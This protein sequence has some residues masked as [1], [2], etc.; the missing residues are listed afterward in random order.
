[1]IKFYFKVF[2]VNF[3][4]MVAFI[5]LFSLLRPE[6]APAAPTAVDIGFAF[7]LF[8]AMAA[9]ALH[10]LNILMVKRQA[11]KTALPDLYSTAQELELNVS[12]PYEKLFDLCRRYVTDKAAYTV[13]EEDQAKG[14]ISARTPWSW[15]GYG[16]TFSI[17]FSEI[18]DGSAKVRIS[19]KPRMPAVLLDYGENLGNVLRA[20]DYI[21]TNAH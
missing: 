19:S 1:M 20:R 12:M 3:I 9:G 14:L 6:A 15:K 10:K 21:Q 8:M 2:F 13:T 11:G 17:K 7:G 18:K 4:L 16:N 5:F